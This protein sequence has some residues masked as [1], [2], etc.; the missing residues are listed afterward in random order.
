MELQPLVKTKS[1]VGWYT[2]NIIKYLCRENIDL[3]GNV[4]NFLGRNNI[5]DILKEFN[6]NIEACRFLPY[7][8]YTRMWNYLPIKYN[9]L[10]KNKADIY[11]FFNF[12]VPPKVDGKVIVTVYD[13]VYKVF[14]ETMYN[15]NYRRLEKNLRYSVDRADT[16]ITIS[17]SSKREIIKYLNVDP[18][19]IEIVPPGVEME[20]YNRQFDKDKLMQVKDKYNLP[21]EFMLYLG[22]LEPRKN[23]ESII[24]AFSLYKKSNEDS[25]KLVIAGNKGW[26]YESIFERVKSLNIEDQVVFTGYVDENDKPYVYEMSTIFIFPSLY[27]GFGIPVL[28]AMASKVPVITSDISS[29]KEVCGDAA[30]FV[31]PK[32]LDAICDDITKLRQNP[33]IGKQLIEK[34]LTRC[35]NFT[36]EKSA[37]KLINI[38][39][40]LS[41]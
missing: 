38:Y 30:L 37:A 17:E 23:I 27:E 25:I 14:P 3:Q 1:G 24:D 4:F 20:A 18:N 39:E 29:L 7:S 10:F 31:N 36:W 16:I 22:T 2:Y 40:K 11:H 34:G 12:I 13:M 33:N 6:F 28:E 41:R 8:V 9:S 19:K 21:E 5:D 35:K 32:D 26:M 15:S